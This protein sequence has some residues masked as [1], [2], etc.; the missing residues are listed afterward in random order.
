MESGE[1]I[2]LV[3]LLVEFLG[4][5]GFGFAMGLFFF[6]AGYFATQA[7]DR[8]GAGKFMVD[9]LKRLG[10]PWLFFELALVPML[11]YIVDIHGGTNCSGG[12]YECTYQGSLWSYLAL[13]PRNQASISDGPDW[14]LEAL[15]IFSFGY[16]LWRLATQSVKVRPYKDDDQ[17]HAVPENWTPCS[18]L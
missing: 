14:F 3:N 12:L 9:R 5:I 11:N 16:V 1:T 18:L 2:P 13:Y 8:K 6:I 15:L 7:Y 10:I 17:A 4:I